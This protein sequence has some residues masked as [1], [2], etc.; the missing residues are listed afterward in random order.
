MPE[1]LKTLFTS[2]NLGEKLFALSFLVLILW[3]LFLLAPVVTGGFSASISRQKVEGLRNHPAL[4]SEIAALLR[5]GT[6]QSVIDKQLSAM[7]AEQT[8]ACTLQREKAILWG[9]AALVIVGLAILTLIVKKDL[10]KDKRNLLLG[11][12]ITVML[13][14][15]FTMAVRYI[16]PDPRDLSC[17]DGIKKLMKLD[18]LYRVHALNRALYNAW[19]SEYFPLYDIP[20]IDVPADSRP[21]VW[22]RLFFY[23][24]SFSLPRRLLYANV[25]YILASSEELDMLSRQGMPLKKIGN[26]SYQGQR[27][28]IGELQNTLPRFFAPQSMVSLPKLEEAQAFM[29]DPKVDPRAVSVLHSEKTFPRGEGTNIVTL[30]NFS[31]EKVELKANF[32][33]PGCVVLA[34]EPLSGWY[35]L[36]DGEKQTAER[37]NLMQ[38]AVSVP[39][40][41]HLV[42]FVYDKRDLSSVVC[43]IMH[44]VFL[45]VFA[46][47]TLVVLFL[48]KKNAQ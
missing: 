3:G 39:A 32:S 12:I 15:G 4:Q 34:C 41:E 5:R 7:A 10:P 48:K 18:K 2:L 23:D 8:S 31:P 33:F 6:P 45:P 11:A 47:F 16:E 13:I 17:P 28:T 30:V 14:Q 40:G 20:C 29:N 21:S 27:Q 46:V 35:A 26:F 37:C 22:R 44:V 25:R 42:T 1:K 36:V 38:Q 9:L 19:I 43:D 24:P